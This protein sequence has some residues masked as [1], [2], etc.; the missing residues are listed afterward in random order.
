M[1]A[2]SRQTVAGVE[3]DGRR[4][5]IQPGRP[6]R[7]I[8]TVTGLGQFIPDPPS[9]VVTKEY[10]RE[11]PRLLD[12]SAMVCAYLEERAVSILRLDLTELATYCCTVLTSYEKDRRGPLARFAGQEVFRVILGTYEVETSTSTVRTFTV[13]WDGTQAT[14]MIS[15]DRHFDNAAIFDVLAYGETDYLD[16]HVYRGVGRQFLTEPTIDLLTK[17]RSIEEI[18]PDE[19]GSA[20]KNIIGAASR[21]TETVPAPSGIGGPI[22]ALLLGTEPLPRHV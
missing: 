4:K 13:S 5:L 14:Y 20:V 1:A 3:Y 21:T 18:S 8:I 16:E 9:G 19:A 11:A 7:T 17:P 6:E 12:I 15:H 10:V 2:D 22:D